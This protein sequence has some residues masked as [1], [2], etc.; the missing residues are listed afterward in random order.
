MSGIGVTVIAIRRRRRR[1]RCWRGGSVGSVIGLSTVKMKCSSEIARREEVSTVWTQV[2]T[3]WTQRFQTEP[4]QR[5]H[6]SP[7]AEAKRCLQTCTL[8]RSPNPC[9]NAAIEPMLA[10]PIRLG[11]PRNGRWG[12]PHP[13]RPIP[14]RPW[15]SRRV[16]DRS[17]LGGMFGGGAP[18]QPHKNG[19][20][21]GVNFIFLR[22]LGDRKLLTDE[23]ASTKA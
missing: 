4:Q 12:K 23:F 5:R 11:S 20:G 19:G 13:P 10:T 17:P 22:L 6:L 18:C 3:V 21:V 9:R 7:A 1:R 14:D 2:S 8:F 15:S 16:R